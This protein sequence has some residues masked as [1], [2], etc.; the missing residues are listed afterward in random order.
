MK[1]LIEGEEETGGEHIEAYVKSSPPRLQADAAVICDTEMFAPELPTICVGLRGMVYCELFVQGAN[2]DLHSGV[3]G[4]AAPNPHPGHRRDSLR[5]ERPRRPHPDPRL[6]RS[7]RAAQSPKEREA[8]A[9]LPFDEKEY[10]EK[11]MGARELV[12][13]PG[14]PL[15][16]RVVGAAHARSPRHPRRIHRRR[17]ED[18]D[19]RRAPSPRSARAWWPISGPMKPPSSCARRCRPHAQGRDGGIEGAAHAARRR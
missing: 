12:G 6:L 2:H 16:E 5:A 1:F 15:F 14:V 18:R 8:W 11:E 19:S 9:R 7:R 13:E 4:G 17:R 10:T 3:Y